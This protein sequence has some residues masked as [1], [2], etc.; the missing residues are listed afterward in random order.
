MLNVYLGQYTPTTTNY[1][2]TEINLEEEQNQDE[3]SIRVQVSRAMPQWKNSK[4]SGIVIQICTKGMN[5]YTI[6]ARSLV[7]ELRRRILLGFMP[8]EV[9]LVIDSE[10]AYNIFK[11][12][13]KRNKIV[14]LG[15]SIT[16][17]FP[18]GPQYSWAHIAG[19]YLG[20]NMINLGENGDTTAGMLY[21]FTGQV[22]AHNPSHVI[23]MGGIN[24]VVMEVDTQSIKDNISKIVFKSL[25]NGI[26]PIIGITTPIISEMIGWHSKQIILALEELQEW[27]RI[28][29]N[30]KEIPAIDFC[31]TLLG[32]DG[33]AMEELFVDGGHPSREGYAKMA[34]KAIDILGIIGK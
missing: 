29:T 8:V 13:A 2:M 14:C 32:P 7:S 34:L 20:L 4:E 18:H 28:F 33:R 25:T 27:L 5:D 12:M 11:V 6:L 24:D 10:E 23:I 17:G 31:S 30:E 9:A 15:D 1:I 3:A 16:Y 22:I 21:R 19:E 26:C